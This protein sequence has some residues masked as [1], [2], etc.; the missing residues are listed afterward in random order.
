MAGIIKGI[1]RLQS[2][3]RGFQAGIVLSGMRGSPAVRLLL[4]WLAISLVMLPA[5]AS[6]AMGGHD[7]SPVV[8]PKRCAPVKCSACQKPDFSGPCPV[9]VALPDSMPLVPPQPSVGPD[10]TIDYDRV[11]TR[12]WGHNDARYKL[13]TT[14][15]SFC[16]AGQEKV[17][18]TGDVVTDGYRVVVYGMLKGPSCV[19]RKR[20]EENIRRTIAHELMH[21][22]YYFSLF[23][24]AKAKTGMLYD[25]AQACVQAR[26]QWLEQFHRDFAQMRERQETHQDFAG[27]IKYGEACDGSMAVELPA[28]MY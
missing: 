1:G 2:L 22:D 10:A 24:Q 23:N 17:A 14:C 21:R 25:T 3:W 8:R 27:E 7:K 6:P 13:T 15:S 4:S 18:F 12:D 19:K 16:L 11:A 5:Q 26:D 20:S 9:C 28:G